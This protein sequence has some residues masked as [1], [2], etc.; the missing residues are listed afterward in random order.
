MIRSAPVRV[1]VANCR[2]PGAMPWVASFSGDCYAE[3][4]A[5]GGMD[6]VDA[7]RADH[8]ATLQLFDDARDRFETQIGNIGDVLTG[9]QDDTASLI[10]E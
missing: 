3:R 10:G 6:A 4:E 9:G 5:A 2:T 1:N 8:L 7:D